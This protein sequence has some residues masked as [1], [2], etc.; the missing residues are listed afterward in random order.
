MALL[1][2]IA[3]G[4]A[5]VYAAI[6][7]LL[8]F[9]QTRLIFPRGMVMPPAG[10]LPPGAERLWLDTPDGDRLAGLRIPAVGNPADDPP[11]LTIL[12][13]GGNAWH[14]DALAIYLHELYPAAGIVAFHYRGYAPS[15]GSPSARALRADAPLIYDHVAGDGDGGRAPGRIVVVGFS[16]GAAVAAHLAAER[17]VAGLILVSPFDSMADLAQGHYPWLPARL[18]LRHRLPTID[19]ARRVRAPTALIAAADDTIVPPERTDP[20]RGAFANLVLDRT[21]AGTD[22]I[23]IYHDPAFEAAMV[24][25]L[26][27]IDE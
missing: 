9:S 22:H 25:A 20:L 6:A 27:R 3:L 19:F 4:L 21:I 13:F 12:G 8:F 16:L 2:K 5:A 17:P 11:P 15:T 23:T 1:I 24:A 18:L 26:R 10:P 7:L 14:A